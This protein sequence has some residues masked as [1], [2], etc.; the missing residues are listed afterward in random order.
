MKDGSWQRAYEAIV[1]SHR[2]LLDLSSGHFDGTHTPAKRGGEA[3]AYQGRKKQK[4][5]NTLWLVDAK[6]LPVSFSKPVAGNH[7]DLFQNETYLKSIHK[8][9]NNMNLSTEGL[10]INADA[11]FDS[12][13][14][15]NNCQRYGITPNI[16]SNNRN[17]N[18]LGDDYVYF[19]E[20]LYDSRYIVERTNAWMGSNRIL[21][22]RHE[23]ILRNWIGWHYMFCIKQ[24]V[25][26][27]SKL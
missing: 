3:V 12:K 7:H 18:D 27:I 1:Q 24:W 19:D 26:E 4:T 6:G 17:T 10:F 2:G 20:L 13:E 14:F 22:I 16:S 5:S 8:Q 15:R 21:L 9:M 11:G 25:N 23:T